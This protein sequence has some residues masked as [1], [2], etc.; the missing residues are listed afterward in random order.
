MNPFERAA[1]QPHYLD[2]DD[3]RL[4]YYTSGRGE[5]PVVW[6]HGL[7]LDSRS[8]SAQRAHF[9]PLA[10]NVFVDL[11]GYGASS[12][13][14]LD[15]VDVTQVYADD[16]DR[17]L[18]HLDL[19][20]VALI[21]FASAGHVALRF[22]AQHPHRLAKLAVIN[23]SPRFRR[24]G[25]WPWGFD[26]AGIDRFVQIGREGGIEALTDVILEPGTVFHDVG[27]REAQDLRNWFG[28]MSR[29]AGTDTLMGFFE[30]IAR[31][32]DRHLLG[33]VTTPTMLVTSGL[34]RE[35]PSDVGLYL[36]GHIAE[37][38]LVELPG[39][40]H[41]AFATRPRLVNELLAHFLFDTPAAR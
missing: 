15:R 6:L 30:G 16:L 33:S 34:G 14:P 26:D 7:P 41:F 36:R 13:L 18:M 27:R 11:R 1:W 19:R 20:N 31:D 29:T 9:D 4:A 22:A 17:L 12:K 3:A 39:A 5:E 35:V 37:S 32:D 21:G 10:R 2:V 23:A 8:W 25:D 38:W 28:A 24:G 40:D